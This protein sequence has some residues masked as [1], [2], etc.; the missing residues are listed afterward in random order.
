M[1]DQQDAA[2]IRPW[3]NGPQPLCVTPPAELLSDTSWQMGYGERSALEGLLSQRKP[4][5][6]LEIGTAAGGSLRRIAHHSGEVHSLDLDEPAPELRELANVTFHAGD[7]HVLLSET[8]AAFAEQDRV[9][10]FVLVDGDHSTDGVRRDLED[11]LDSPATGNTMIVI[12]DTMNDVVRAGLEAVGFE[13][14]PKV[15]YVELDFVPGYMF[16]EPTLLGEGGA[17]SGWW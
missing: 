2:A 10:D 17:A 1:S 15:A 14:W 8:L 9:V 13:A 12:H 5:L 7:S 6:A 11:L 16:R 3:V 4:A